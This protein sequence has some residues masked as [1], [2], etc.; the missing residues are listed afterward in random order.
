MPHRGWDNQRLEAAGSCYQPL[1]WKDS[2]KNGYRGMEA[3][4]RSTERAAWRE[5]MP[6]LAARSLSEA[7]D[8]EQ[9]L[10]FS[11]HPAFWSFTIISYCELLR[12]HSWE[13]SLGKVVLYNTQQNR[14]R[15][16][17]GFESQAND[18]HSSW[19]LPLPC[20][21]HLEEGIHSLFSIISLLFYSSA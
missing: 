8:R 5:L 7:G 10:T 19:Q 20:L 4:A 3:G 2:E 17:N 21:S 18:L 16:E 14:E 13:G 1:G 6:P 12:K 11:P 9:H 15:T